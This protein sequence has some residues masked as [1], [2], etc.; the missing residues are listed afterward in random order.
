MY[1]I[2]RFQNMDY[3]AYWRNILKYIYSRQ[4][5]FIDQSAYISTEQY[6]KDGSYKFTHL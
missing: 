5:S 6:Y 4:D 3:K 2:R 1:A